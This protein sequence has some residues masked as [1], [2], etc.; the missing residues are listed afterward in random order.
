MCV[1]IIVACD[2]KQTRSFHYVDDLVEGVWRFAQTGHAGPMNIGNP[3]EVSMLELAELIR[4][5]T[6]S[7]SEVAFIE[8]PQDDPTVRQPDITLAREVLG[9]EP[10]VPLED[11]L[12]RTIEWFR[13]HP[14]LLGG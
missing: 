2:V 12:K 4:T 14:E 10:K 11:G 8:R 3:H 5:L 1:H 13:R 7:T 9:W 6:G